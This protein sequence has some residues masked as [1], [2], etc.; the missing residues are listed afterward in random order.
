MIGELKGYLAAAGLV[1]AHYL[2][3]IKKTEDDIRK[4]WRNEAEKRVKVQ[5]A[6]FE[7]AKKEFKI[8]F[9]N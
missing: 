8:I 3:H 4:E 5:F 2:D 7:I 1:W 6:L 9:F